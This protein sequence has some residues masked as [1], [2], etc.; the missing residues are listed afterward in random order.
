MLCVEI[1]LL[2]I[3]G[4]VTRNLWQNINGDQQCYTN[5]ELKLVSPQSLASCP[6]TFRNI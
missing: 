6:A 5:Y 2:A 3:I 4:I 1:M